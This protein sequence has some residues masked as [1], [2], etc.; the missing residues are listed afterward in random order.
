[1]LRLAKRLSVLILLLDV[2][3]VI[4]LTVFRPYY[5]PATSWSRQILSRPVFQP[6]QIIV[7]WRRLLRPRYRFRRLGFPR[8]N[9][10]LLSG[11]RLLT[12]RRLVRRRLSRT[13]R[14]VGLVL[15]PPWFRRFA[16]LLLLV[17][18]PG[19][20]LMRK[21]VSSLVSLLSPPVL[22]G[23]GWLLLIIPRVW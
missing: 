3:F 22:S 13:Q 12:G 19:L 15:V 4:F 20:T 23:V 7:R 6:G 21:P 14:P 18:G 9:M 11:R 8:K 2:I 10:S 5:F 17:R 16:L 1:M